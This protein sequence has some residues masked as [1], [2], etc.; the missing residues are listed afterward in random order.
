MA[1]EQEQKAK[2]STAE[3]P[4]FS[5]A[6]IS[7]SKTSAARSARRWMH[8]VVQAR[9]GLL[10]LFAFV[11]VTLRSCACPCGVWTEIFFQGDP[12]ACLPPQH[13]KGECAKETTATV[14]WTEATEGKC[15]LWVCFFFFLGCQVNTGIIVV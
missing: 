15:F 13:W 9:T 7:S 4:L 12:F 3:C 14:R 2:S 10:C 8:A 11:V 1:Q 6:K 5:V